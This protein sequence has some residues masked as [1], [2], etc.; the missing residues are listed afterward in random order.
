MCNSNW[1]EW[2]TIKGVITQAISKSDECKARGRFEITSTITPW[3]V[4]HK[5]QSLI[6]CIYTNFGIKNVFWEPL[7]SESVCSAFLSFENC[8]KHCWA[9]KARVINVE[10]MWVSNYMCLITKSSNRTPVI[11]HPCDCTA[12]MWQIG[13][14]RTNHDQEFCY[15]YY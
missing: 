1:T 12:I 8:I 7:L 10:I 5:V 2:S 15:R 13:A 4:Q 3:I 9:I 14:Q 6:N 11:G